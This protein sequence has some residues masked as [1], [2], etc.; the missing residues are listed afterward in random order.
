VVLPISRLFSAERALGPR[1]AVDISLGMLHGAMLGEALH[2]AEAAAGF[3]H[4]P[5]GV[6]DECSAPGVR[7][8]TLETELAIERSE[9][10]DNTAR[11]DHMAFCCSND[12]GAWVTHYLAWATLTE[13]ET[14][15]FY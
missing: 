12:V 8:A 10:V 11:P 5:S 7:A 4:E 13:Y 14:L 9:P 2:V 1:T 6:G 3:E 15:I